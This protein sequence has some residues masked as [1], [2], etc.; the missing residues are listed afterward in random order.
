[1]V[2]R[3]LDQRLRKLLLSSFFFHLF[4]HILGSLLH[5]HSIF[6]SH[7]FSNPFISSPITCFLHQLLIFIFQLFIAP[8]PQLLETKKLRAAHWRI[9]ELLES[10]RIMPCPVYPNYANR[11]QD[12]WRQLPWSCLSFPSQ[13]FQSEFATPQP[14]FWPSLLQRLSYRTSEHFSC[15]LPIS[16]F[17]TTV[18]TKKL[19]EILQIFKNPNFDVT[20][21][22]NRIMSVDYLNRIASDIAKLRKKYSLR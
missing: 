8:S 15:C 7:S 19:K 5:H 11:Q 14:F 2:R 4:I 13:R 12:N 17:R 3:F 21:F 9:R 20:F 10:F 1:M 22:S 16:L 6:L 18:G